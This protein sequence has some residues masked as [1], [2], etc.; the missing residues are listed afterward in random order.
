[1]SL[2]VNAD[3]SDARPVSP[4]SLPV[5]TTTVI[6]WRPER[7]SRAN[8][9]G[10]LR[11]WARRGWTV[12]RCEPRVLEGPAYGALLVLEREALQKRL[13]RRPIHWAADCEERSSR[14]SAEA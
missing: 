7:N 11:R 6:V 2:P 12:R 13:Q 1:M 4:G 10:L 3:D 9:E 5:E 14:E 8:L